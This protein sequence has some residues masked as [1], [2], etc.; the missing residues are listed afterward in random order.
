MAPSVREC[1]VALGAM[2]KDGYKFEEQDINEHVVRNCR[3]AQKPRI[4]IAHKEFSSVRRVM[5][6]FK[7]PYVSCHFAPIHRVRPVTALG[8]T[9]LHTV[10]PQATGLH[11]M[12]PQAMDPQALASLRVTSNTVNLC[13][14]LLAAVPFFS[15]MHKPMLLL[16]LWNGRVF[17][18]VRCPTRLCWR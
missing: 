16:L 13:L 3:L 4:R 18:P 15:E 9:G 14:Y 17:S 5:R 10:A 7:P 8:A 11:T 6:D 12:A 2:T 1:F